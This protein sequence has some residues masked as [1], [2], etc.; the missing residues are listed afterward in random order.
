MSITNIHFVPTHNMSFSMWQS[1]IKTPLNSTSVETEQFFFLLLSSQLIKITTSSLFLENLLWAQPK[2]QPLHK[3]IGGITGV[4]FGYLDEDFFFSFPTII[5][6]DITV[7]SFVLSGFWDGM[8]CRAVL[9]L[10]KPQP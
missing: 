1:N 8:D 10:N 7:L 3:C 5:D 2:A 9:A 6:N 4:S